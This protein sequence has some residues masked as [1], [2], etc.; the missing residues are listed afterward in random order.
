V[1]DPALNPAAGAAVTSS[2]RYQ[3]TLIL[4]LSFNFGVVFLD[5]NAF[6]FLAPFIQPELGLSNTQVG[7]VASALSFSWAIAGL[8]MGRLSDK[9]GRRKLLLVVSTLVFSAA[10]VLSGFAATFVMLLGA[11]L[12]MGLAEGGIMPISQTLIAAEVA[13]ER[14][15]LAMGITQNFGANVIA[16][17]LGPIVLIGIAAAL[18][19]RNAF[20][21]AAIPGFVIALLIALLLRDPPALPAAARTQTDGAGIRSLLADRSIVICILMSVLLVAYLVV[22]SVFTPLYLVNLRGIDQQ[23]MSYVMGSFGFASILIAFLVPGSSD[24]FG[25]RPVAI[26][27][28]L[29]GLVLPAGLLL[30]TGTAVTPIIACIAVGAAISGVFP[31]VMATVPSEIAP[32]TL[33]ATALSLTMGISEIV[34]GVFAPTIAG[35]LADGYGLAAPIWL[36][37]GLALATGLLA[38]GL[39]ETAPRV[40]ARRGKPAAATA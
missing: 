33:T 13:P 32:R 4:L 25:R 20:Y 38:F 16:N 36:L 35:R 39:R 29:L 31:M 7:L 18:G 37:V 30:T 11:R 40:L 6:N 26:V 28:S 15:G 27:A 23:V 19:W 34:G 14:R 10:S 1:H 8:F 21:L 17:S 2:P 24:F 9:L 22:F 5:R 12:L 3:W